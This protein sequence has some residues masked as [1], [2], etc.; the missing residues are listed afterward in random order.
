[1]FKTTAPNN[2]GNAFVDRND[3]ISL[4]GTRLVAADQNIK[5]DELVALVES[6]GQTLKT[7]GDYTTQ[8]DLAAAI[9]GAGGSMWCNETG[10]ANAYIASSYSPKESSPILFNGLTIMFRPTN[11][12][13]GAS[14]LNYNSLGVKDITLN[15]GDA[16]SGGE[17]SQFVILRYRSTQNRWEIQNQLPQNQIIYNSSGT[18]SKPS[19]LK[20]IVVEVIGGG[21]GGGGVDGQGAGTWA[22]GGG[23]G[24]GGYTKE[25][26]LASALSA[27]ET[28]TVGA[29]GGGGAGAG[30]TSGTSGGTSS[31]GSFCSAT[32]G[33]G[34]A[35]DVAGADQITSLGGAG[36]VGSNGDINVAGGPGQYGV[37]LENVAGR[38]NSGAGGSSYLGG[39][40][41]GVTTSS[42][43]EDAASKGAGGSG[44]AVHAVADNLAGGD[45]EDGIVIVTEFF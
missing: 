37:G 10:A 4:P 19:N 27:S 1:M 32:G 24:A 21:G 25:T 9:Y 38:Y 34:G 31:F 39:G 15:G 11:I 20:F 41:K 2:V 44:G 18:Y 28:V 6:S 14:T 7:T 8:V 30:G 35:G 5:Q 36:G 13:T 45:G 22:A 26:L 29:G 17:M 12:N 43:G 40:G 23:G 42:A 3:S 33:A 16:L